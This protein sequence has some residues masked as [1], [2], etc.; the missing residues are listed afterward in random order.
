MQTRA[1]VLYEHHTPWKIETIELD[2]PKAGEVLVKLAAT[3]LCHSDE[4]SVT[5][6]MPTG[7]PII[8]GH[9]GAGRVEAVGPGV[10]L[11][12]QRLGQRNGDRSLAVFA[13]FPQN[14]LSIA[15]WERRSIV[16]YDFFLARYYFLRIIGPM[17]ARCRDSIAVGSSR[18]G[19]PKALAHKELQIEN[20]PRA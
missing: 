17:L 13:R 10:Y 20:L 18:S 16:Q 15:G 8:G 14:G 11:A 7:F 6:D 2:P 5:G 9:E 4:H 12:E 19:D 3:G 1:A